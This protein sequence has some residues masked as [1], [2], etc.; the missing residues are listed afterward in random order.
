LAAYGD[1]FGYACLLARAWAEASASKVL[2]LYRQ[3]WNIEEEYKCWKSRAR[4]AR[5]FHARDPQGIE[6]E[7][8]A[9]VTSFTLARMV[10]A[11]AATQQ[12]CD[13]RSIR[14][15]EGL[16]RIAA[17]LLVLVFGSRPRA[18]R[19]LKVLL[20]AL[21][22]RRYRERPGRSYPRRSLA[23]SPKWGP[24]GRRARRKYG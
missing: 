19:A 8:W 5:Q 1:A 22:E 2:W 24:H 18:A 13:Y 4:V 16:T 6:Q 10:F 14:L 7:V 11:E 9:L 23:P 12:G 3:R 17:S 21:T 20:L 15:K